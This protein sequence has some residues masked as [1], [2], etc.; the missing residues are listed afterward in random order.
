MYKIALV[1]QNGASTGIM[2]KKMLAAAQQEGIEVSIKAYSFGQLE[3]FISDVDYV[4]F[5]PQLAFK[6]DQTQKEF[7]Q[8]VD[9]INTIAAVDFGMMRGEKVLKETIAA[10]QKR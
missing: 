2:V 4:L 9:K 6:K 5:G 7:P 1:C 3:D 8:Y 10:I